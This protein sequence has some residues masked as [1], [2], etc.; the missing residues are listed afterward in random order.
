MN[1][2]GRLIKSLSSFIYHNA[3]V[4]TLS[5]DQLHFRHY[6]VLD[7][8]GKTELS[9]SHRTDGYSTTDFDDIADLNKAVFYIINNQE[10]IRNLP[11]A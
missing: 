5:G 1:R 6:G 9:K 7:S 3:V 4:T 10:L 11:K 2:E 8:D